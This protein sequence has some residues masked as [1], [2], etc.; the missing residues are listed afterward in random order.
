MGSS[1]GACE[2]PQSKF[3]L[4]EVEKLV[5]EGISIRAPMTWKKRI[6]HNRNKVEDHYWDEDG[7]HELMIEALIIDVGKRSED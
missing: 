2:E 7:L 5:Y 3:I 4:K 1:K 6:R